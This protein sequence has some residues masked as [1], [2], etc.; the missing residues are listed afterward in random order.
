MNNY[1]RIPAI[2]VKIV[3][4]SSYSFHLRY[5]DDEEDDDAET[6][7]FQTSP[8]SLF[9]EI[10]EF[11]VKTIIIKSARPRR[12]LSRQRSSPVGVAR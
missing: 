7:A 6:L 12:L 4:V 2:I 5:D 3:R 1:L 10:I 9:S 11:N 8:A